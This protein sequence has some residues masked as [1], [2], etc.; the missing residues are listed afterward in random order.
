MTYAKKI[1]KSEAQIDWK[2]SAV[3]VDRHIRGLSPFPGAWFAD[4]NQRVKV[5]MSNV[6]DGTGEAGEI[7]DQVTVACSDGAVSLTRLQRAGK[8][9][10]DADVFTR[11]YPLPNGKRL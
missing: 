5:L 11:G 1:E 2:Q 9:A 8:G 3:D 10:M 4:G 6:A 7:I